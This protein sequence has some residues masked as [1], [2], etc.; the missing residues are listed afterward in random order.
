MDEIILAMVKPRQ[1][2]KALEDLNATLQ[3]QMRDMRDRL[4]ELEAQKVIADVNA[5]H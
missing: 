1:R 3:Q 2:I 4:V 5:N